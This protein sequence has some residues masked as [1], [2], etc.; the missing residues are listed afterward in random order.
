MMS[1]RVHV[2]RNLHKK[3]WSLRGRNG[4]VS[5]YRD[6]LCL[7]DCK[8]VVWQ[9]LRQRVLERR[10]KLIHAFV[11]G[12]E[13]GLPTSLRGWTRIHYNPY[14]H[15]TFVRWEDRTPIYF[16]KKVFFSK[17]GKVYAYGPSDV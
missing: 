11:R 12:E 2:Y 8:F 14:H 17:D 5:G 1:T 16:A 9:G 7:E 3:N 13:I 6:E 10:Q 15:E 4:R